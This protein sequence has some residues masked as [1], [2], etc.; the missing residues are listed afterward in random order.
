MTA[1]RRVLIS[2]LALEQ[3]AQQGTA[4]D[5]TVAPV[6]FLAL[7][8][9]VGE[10]HPAL[11][12]AF[13]SRDITGLSTKHTVLQ[14][15][16]D[17]YALLR[18]SPQLVWV[19]THSAGADRPIYAELMARG[20]TVTTSSG[21]NAA[22]VA[23]SALAG[24]LALARQFPALFAA[25][26]QR[27]WAP[28]VAGTLPQDLAGQTAV[29]LGWGPI[30][31]T[32]QPLLSLLGLQVLV[33]RRSAEAAAPGLPTLQFTALHTVLPRADWLL[34]CCPLNAQTQGSVNAD[35][36]RQLP[37]G[38]QLVNVAR[39]EILVEADL[40]QALQSGHLA[41]AYLDVFEH[42]PL[43]ANS[44]LWALPNVIL[45]PHSAG[46][47]AGNATRVVALFASNLRRWL[48]GQPLAHGVR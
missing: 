38:A 9:L 32:L 13:I 18:R 45:T 24:L 37:R 20:V 29:L 19:H 31:Q 41:G 36:L 22:V 35:V 27:R 15:L 8:D 6:Q 10:K 42:E 28:L 17:C 21:S 16:A 5:E 23:Q 25:Q 39:G 14:P 26:Q 30:A 4:L 12:A 2:R 33:V 44:A 11:D 46:H 40:I 1:V 3:L 48:L 7:E 43:A 34:L 47:S